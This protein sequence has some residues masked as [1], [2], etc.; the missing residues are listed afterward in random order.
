MDET[1]DIKLPPW[2]AI[3]NSALR[4]NSLKKIATFKLKWKWSGVCPIRN[5]TAGKFMEESGIKGLPSHYSKYPSQ[6]KY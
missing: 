2:F 6:L 3:S 4:G 5:M 1:F